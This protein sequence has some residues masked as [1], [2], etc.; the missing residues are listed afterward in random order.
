MTI[1]SIGTTVAIVLCACSPLLC[2]AADQCAPAGEPARTQVVVKAEKSLLA[3][4]ATRAA[5]ADGVSTGAALAAGAAEANPL[6]T[7]SPLGLVALTAVKI[8][9]VSY[10]TQLPEPDKRVVMKTTTALW[11]GAA[12]N[13]LM[14]L[15]AAPPPFPLIAGVAMAL[16]G[17]RHVAHGYAE[18]DRLAALSA[19]AADKVVA[20]GA[21]AADTAVAAVSAAPADA[22]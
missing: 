14:V 13:N 6:V 3:E 2:K 9:L 22:N 15:V 8:A 19:P 16:I 18:Q 17:W 12:L 1:K 4:P 11:G 10:A 21:P 5:I 7:P 20:C